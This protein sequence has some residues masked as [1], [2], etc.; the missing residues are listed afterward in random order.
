MLRFLIILCATSFT[1]LCAL[2]WLKWWELSNGRMLDVGASWRPQLRVWGEW[3]ILHT[4]HPVSSGVQAQVRRTWAWVRAWLLEKTAHFFHAIARAIQKAWQTVQ[5]IQ[6][7]RPHH[8]V[9][10]R[11]S[12]F[13]REVAEY[14]RS[15]A[16][17]HA[18]PKPH[19]A[20]E[21][22]AQK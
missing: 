13:L 7:A 21:E 17:H 6:R 5:N 9:A 11:A 12:N 22:V 20:P 3:V 1:G 14:K 10:G 8:P 4:M 15:L 19:V 16:H 18:A 2:L